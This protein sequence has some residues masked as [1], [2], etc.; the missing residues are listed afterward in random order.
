LQLYIP[1][2]AYYIMADVSPFGFADDYAFV[3]YLV[4]EIG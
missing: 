2:G 4:E 3:K 1:R